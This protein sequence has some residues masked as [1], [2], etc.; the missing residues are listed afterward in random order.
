MKSKRK[1]VLVILVLLI[2]ASCIASA[3]VGLPAIAHQ[4]DNVIASGP[5][6]IITALL[7]ILFTYNCL[8]P[9]VIFAILGVIVWFLY[10]RE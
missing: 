9:L 2:L 4:I 3:V 5:G 10:F 7:G 6:A 1:L 8:I